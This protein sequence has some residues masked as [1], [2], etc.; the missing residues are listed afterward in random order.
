MI[1]DFPE[2]DAPTI[3]VVLP[4]SNVAVKSS[5][6]FC[7]G[8]VVYLKLTFLN[9]IVP[10]ISPI[11]YAFGSSKRILGFLSMISNAD[12]PATIP[13]VTALIFGVAEPREKT[14]K[15]IPKKQERISPES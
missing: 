8:L 14:P 7:S 6:I 4:D 15:I 12:L 3:A 13:S 10:L 1:V 9:S 11:G 5:R 2:P